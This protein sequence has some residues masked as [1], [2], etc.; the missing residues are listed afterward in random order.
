MDLTSKTME[1]I[2]KKLKE[3]D[4]EIDLKNDVY[5]LFV[6]DGCVSIWY[7]EDEKTIK[8]SVELLPEN[9]SYILFKNDISVNELICLEGEGE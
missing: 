6:K 1:I 9:N 2:K 3:M 4:R 8:I 7:D 5:Y